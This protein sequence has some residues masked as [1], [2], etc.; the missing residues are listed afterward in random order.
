MQTNN[1][2]TSVDQVDQETHLDLK[3]IV[4]NL[5][6]YWHWYFIS[7]LICVTLAFVY[8]YFATSLYKIHSSLLVENVQSSNSTSSSLLDETSLLNDLGLA[9]VTNSVDNEM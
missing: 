9:N 5:L 8:L 4:F 1:N 2:P 7:L 6:S 3:K